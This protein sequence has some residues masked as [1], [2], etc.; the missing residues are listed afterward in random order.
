V[1]W[2]RAGLP[3]EF[4]VVPFIGH[5]AGKF[6]TDGAGIAI[7]AVP[8]DE[9]S[10]TLA[11]YGQG[12]DFFMCSVSCSWKAFPPV[13]AVVFEWDV[14]WI[15]VFLPAAAPVNVTSARGSGKFSVCLA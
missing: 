11:G 13:P 5:A 8:G 4:R 1:E 14:P 9:Y 12:P 7:V 3:R 15:V 2:V 6:R 10:V